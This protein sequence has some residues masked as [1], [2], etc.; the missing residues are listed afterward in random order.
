MRRGWVV[1]AGIALGACGGSGRGP[2]PV[3]PEVLMETS[4]RQFRAGQFSAAR[5]GFERASFEVAANDPISAEARYYLAE[6]QFALGEYP[7]AARNFRR[8]A[9]EFPDHPLAPDAL[10]RSGDALAAQWRRPQLDPT[11]ADE[12]LAEYRELLARYPDSRAAE[13]VRLKIAELAE[14]YAEKNY[15]AGIFYLRLKAYDSAII[16]FRTIVAQY[17]ET[18]HASESLLRLVETYRRLGYG[19]E[20][21]ETCAHLRQ[22]YPET[23]GIDQTCPA[24]AAPSPGSP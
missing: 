11:P 6:C 13:R 14:Q 10:M 3:A 16:Y 8:V 12:A 1:L 24:A 23:E 21:R 9:D 5:R 18:R 15:R 22:Y 17:P 7:E 19:E 20:Q 4:M 2:A